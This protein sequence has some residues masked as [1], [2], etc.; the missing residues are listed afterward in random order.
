MK[1]DSHFDGGNIEVVKIE[2]P[3]D[4]QLKIR[5]DVNAKYLQWFYFHFTGEKNCEYTFKIINAGEST[6]PQGWE[7]Y[8][9]LASYDGEKWFRTPTHYDGKQL[10]F[11]LR[12]TKNQAYFAYFVPYSYK[13]HQ[14]LIESSL[15][16]AHCRSEILGKTVNGNS[17]QLL[18]IGENSPHKK[19]CWIIA[20]QHPGETMAEWFCE[21]VIKRL[22]DIDDPVT[23]QLLSNAVFFIVP[24]MNPDGSVLGNLRANGAGINLNRQWHSPDIKIAP[25]VFY[26]KQKMKETGIDFFFDAHGDEEKPYV[27]TLNNSINPS[28]NARLQ[29]LENKF[30]TFY[31]NANPDFQ[32]EKGY[33]ANRFSLDELL[34]T[35][36]Y[37]IYR[38]FE[39]LSF[40]LEMPFTDNID[41]PD[42]IYGWS[43][44]RSLQLGKDLLFPL[45]KIIHDLR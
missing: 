32:N 23:K 42:A 41:R 20:R 9:V 40:T 7:K 45:A 10:T 24:N 12:I 11:T 18:Q 16:F 4:I 17:L 8:Q 34:T 38:E 13:R 30:K 21:G 3:N 25:E 28:Y 29:E 27:F 6:Y 2:N 39:C 22:L 44:E 5:K 14:N 33:E 19:K 26:V 43:A 36:P 31:K 35:A 37:A 1:I 15:Q